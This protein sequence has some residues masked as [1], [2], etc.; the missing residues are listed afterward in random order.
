ME[1]RNKKINR[2]L[3]AAAVTF[4]FMLT[5]NVPGVLHSQS[6][7]FAPYWKFEANLMSDYFYKVQGDTTLAGVT[8]YARTPKDFSGFTF[9]R[10]KIW[11]KYFFNENMTGTIAVEGNDGVTGQAGDRIVFIKLAN[12]EFREVIQNS[13]IL[14]GLVPSPTFLFSSEAVWGYRSIE[15]TIADMRGLA[16][17]TDLGV[18]IRGSFSKSGELEYNAMFGNGNGTRILTGKTKKV[19]GSLIARLLEKKLVLELYTDCLFEKGGRSRWTLKGFAGY[20]SE[21]FAAGIEV[22]QQRQ[23]NYYRDSL[24]IVPFGVSAFASGWLIEG[25][26]NAFARFDYFNNDTEFG[27]SRTYSAVQNYYSENFIT[28]GLDFVPYKGIH[29]MPNIWIDTYSD[30]RTSG[31]VE[32]KPD[33]VPRITLF[34]EV[35]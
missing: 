27:Q 25:K 5:L 33:I 2:C 13:R 26:L 9:R 19:Y 31:A 17:S 7:E 11:A 22:I 12:L 16:P 34:Y 8:E 6:K 28:A 35:N 29:V 4:L 20:K 10:A 15:K 24:D 23:S 30:K 14:A 1:E 3:K 32:R 18:L 21:K